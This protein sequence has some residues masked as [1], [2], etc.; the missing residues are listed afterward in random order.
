MEHIG[1]VL[2]AAAV[3]ATAGTLRPVS[4][5]DCMPGVHDYAFLWWA[6]G[7]PAD[8]SPRRGKAPATSDRQKLVCVQTGTY[9]AALDVDK[10]DLVRLGSIAD[11][12][13]ASEVVASGNETVLGLPRSALALTVAL[14]DRVYRCTGRR[15]VKR[16]G[17]LRYPYRLIESGRFLHRFD[18]SD[19]IFAD[20]SGA[21]LEADGRLEL[22]AWPDRLAL[23]LA[24]TPRSD[25]GAARLKIALSPQNAA[26]ESAVSLRHGQVSTVALALTPDGP[27]L[28]PPVVR[29]AARKGK[30]LRTEYD[31][32]R[33]WL[34]VELPRLR[35]TNRDGTY[36]PA[37][38]LDHLERM[39]VSVENPSD[40]PQ[41]A[42]LL[43]AR[44]SDFPG[45]TGFCPMLRDTDG[46][47]TGLPVQLSKNWHSKP[48]ER[49]LYDG[50]W[51]H[52]FSVLRLPPRS[53]L[54]VE[55]AIAYARWGGVPAVSHAQ[56]CL[57][58]WGHNQRWDE[59][60][61][62][63]FGESICY[64]PDGAQRR[65]M[66]DDVRPLMVRGIGEKDKKFGWTNNVGGGD[67]LVY[68]DDKGDYQYY[69]AMKALYTSHGPNLTDV[70]YA[71]ATVD[72]HIDARI[73]V[74]TARA[75]YVLRCF[76]RFRYDVRKSTPFQRLAFYQL[77]SDHYLW[78]AFGKIA[79]GD[80]TGL[81]EEWK[82]HLGGRTYGRT[83]IRCEGEA[84]WFS[85]HESVPRNA[86]GGA[87]ANR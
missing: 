32:A 21:V 74:S 77:G 28:L 46:H 7:V 53:R 5:A 82:P 78:H 59:V 85:L 54:D 29:V 70:T 47:P 58:G 57:I 13:L 1:V 44:D 84:P 26:S 40:A 19:L 65:C 64:E 87:W 37:E 14:G 3:S 50:V 27:P 45:I 61:V 2:L 62:G 18:V 23:L 76:H 30:P 17:F 79:R 35:L 81:A 15:T 39:Q 75:D 10:V 33:Q 31:A 36:F 25:L 55:L 72:G 49:V 20:G 73:T 43:F 38:H 11:A 42:R 66:I 60:A 63:S 22:V 6:N 83:G 41:T 9:G 12:P 4:P 69:R 86:R 68:I 48:G 8:C 67:F 34:R 56:L 16:K 52:G 71:G 80:A 24:I 51:F